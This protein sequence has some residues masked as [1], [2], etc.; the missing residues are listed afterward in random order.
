MKH[1]IPE[2]AN[3]PVEKVHQPWQMTKE[4]EQSS[5]VVVGRD[6]PHPPK[7]R[8]HSSGET[9]SPLQAFVVL[10][11]LHLHVKPDQTHVRIHS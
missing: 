6:Y 11:K 7:S 8:F 2:L 1:W 4:E 10:T 5:G 3:V 9:Y